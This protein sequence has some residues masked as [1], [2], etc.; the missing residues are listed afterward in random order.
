MDAYH[1]RHAGVALTILSVLVLASASVS[2]AN[3]Q[4][5][6]TTV[7]IEGNPAGLTYDSAKGEILVSVGSGTLSIIS[8]S[9]YKVLATLSNTGGG[10]IDTAKDELFANNGSG[11]T[12]ISL[13]NYSV[14]AYLPYQAG[15]PPTA[16]V[17]DSG[18]GEIYVGTYTGLVN[19]ISDSNNSYVSIP[20][21]NGPSYGIPVGSVAAGVLGYPSIAGEAYDSGMGEVFVTNSGSNNVSVVSDSSNSVVAKVNVGS[22]PGSLA[23]DSAKGEVFVANYRAG[24]ISV[25]S[26]SSN[27]VV[28]TMTLP[29]TT[30]ASGAGPFYPTALV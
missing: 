26:D 20:T 21:A 13:S 1:T 10:V 16:V 8:D 2:F 15:Y 24:T 9:T 11:I 23:Y 17:Y 12:V 25:I 18:K 29:M 27:K 22:G 4:T 14:V 30:Y 5:Y 3:A 6:V 7:K 28:D 19:V